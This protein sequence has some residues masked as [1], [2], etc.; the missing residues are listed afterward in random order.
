MA[1][2]KRHNKQPVARR[3]YAIMVLEARIEHLTEDIAHAD[4]TLKAMEE[5]RMRVAGDCSNWCR[6]L[7]ELKAALARLQQPT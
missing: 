3:N 7:N 4:E 1:E 6:E 2:I 5:Q